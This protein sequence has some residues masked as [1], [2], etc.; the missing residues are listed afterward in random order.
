MQVDI[1]YHQKNIQTINA[2]NKHFQG[3][4]MNTRYAKFFNNDQ[5]VNI[6]NF[7]GV[8][9]ISDLPF[10]T[11]N[12]E[13]N[14]I[15]DDVQSSTSLAKKILNKIQNKVLKQHIAKLCNDYFTDLVE[16]K[17]TVKI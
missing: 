13:K 4:R 10:Q 2:I 17:R 11:E 3:V 12:I 7:N 14:V 6:Q 15:E 16:N 1:K 5:F 9:K 8:R